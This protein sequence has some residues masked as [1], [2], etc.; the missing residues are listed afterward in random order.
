MLEQ[1]LFTQ[2]TQRTQSKSQRGDL[3]GL[4]V[5]CVKN[6]FARTGKAAL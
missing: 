5:L 3:C 6:D 4:R 1:N 2:R